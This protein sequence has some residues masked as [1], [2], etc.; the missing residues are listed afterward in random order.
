[1]WPATHVHFD[2]GTDEFEERSPL[3]L[4]KRR[5]S[6]PVVSVEH[7]AA[8]LS[9]RSGGLLLAHASHCTGSWYNRWSSAEDELHDC[10]K[11]NDGPHVKKRVITV[12]TLRH[13]QTASRQASA[14]G[15]RMQTN[16]SAETAAR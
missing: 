14:R 4:G 9:V 3:L 16:L 5:L 7:P 10:L 11:L 8:F 12:K 2:R 13:V 15:S 6:W 1:M